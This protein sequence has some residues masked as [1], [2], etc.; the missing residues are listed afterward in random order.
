MR[1]SSWPKPS[2]CCRLFGN[3]L[4]T[5][6]VAFAFGLAGLAIVYWI[7]RVDGRS[8]VLTLV[9]AGVVTGAFFTALISLVKIQNGDG[10]PCRALLI[11]GK[12]SDV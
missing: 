9:L 4:L 5:V 10:T 12:V 7:S 2:G 1:C 8:P 3:P 11:E 6:V